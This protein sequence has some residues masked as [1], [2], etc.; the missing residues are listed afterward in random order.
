MKQVLQQKL[1]SQLTLTPQLK[2]SLKLLQLPSQALE[3][4]LQIVL[5]SNPLL[6]R[7]E[8]NEIS[9]LKNSEALVDKLDISYNSI[10]QPIAEAAD[11]SI[12]IERTDHLLAEQNLTQSFDSQRID[13]GHQP[14]RVVTSNTLSLIH[15]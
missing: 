8:N 15:I 6:E 11:P 10:P 12:E 5:D 1:S 13:T 7:V 14:G 9:E 2:Q 3:Q 4:E